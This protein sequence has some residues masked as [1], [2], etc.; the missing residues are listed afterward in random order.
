MRVRFRV[1]PSVQGY[2]YPLNICSIACRMPGVNQVG[3]ES[4][5]A[6]LASADT[7]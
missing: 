5:W 7:R 2:A 6:G 1:E 3:F 4:T